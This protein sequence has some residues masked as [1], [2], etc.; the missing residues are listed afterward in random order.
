MIVTEEISFSKRG[1]S[2]MCIRSRALLGTIGVKL[3]SLKVSKNWVNLRHF[4]FDALTKCRVQNLNLTETK[5]SFVPSWATISIIILVSRMRQDTKH[6]CLL[7]PYPGYTYHR[8]TSITLACESN[9]IM[10]VATWLPW[11]HTDH[12][13]NPRFFAA[14]YHPYYSVKQGW[15]FFSVVSFTNSTNRNK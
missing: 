3:T 11:H 1:F 4:H 5:Q 2:D 9:V 8:D 13:L 14:T 12:K 15:I 6:Q 10:I 7:Y